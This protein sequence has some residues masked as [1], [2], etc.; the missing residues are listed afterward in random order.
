MRRVSAW[1]GV[2]FA[3]AL[4]PQTRQRHGRGNHRPAPQPVHH[5]RPPIGTA[6]VVTTSAKISLTLDTLTLDQ[7]RIM[8]TSGKG[9]PEASRWT[10]LPQVF[11]PYNATIDGFVTWLESSS[12][13]REQPGS[14]TRGGHRCIG[15]TGLRTTSN[16]IETC[17]PRHRRERVP[18]ADDESYGFEIARLSQRSHRRCWSNISSRHRRSAVWLSA[19]LR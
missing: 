7:L 6:S 16:A 15:S 19:I 17:G 9:Y 13:S 10:M 8:L 1:L 14:R 2:V 11:P 12:L 5:K 3:S 18:S 4:N